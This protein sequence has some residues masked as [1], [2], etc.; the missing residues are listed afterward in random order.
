MSYF[1]STG[2]LL[3]FSDH[4]NIDRLYSKILARRHMK[5]LS[6]LVLICAKII[7]VTRF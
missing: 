4:L 6:L 7:R 5:G 2:Q 1:L 3:K